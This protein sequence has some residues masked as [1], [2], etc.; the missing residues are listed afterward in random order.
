MWSI[1]VNIFGWGNELR[2]HPQYI[3]YVR[4]EIRAFFKNIDKLKVLKINGLQMVDNLRSSM[5]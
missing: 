3:L 4:Y 1:N 5:E 2:K